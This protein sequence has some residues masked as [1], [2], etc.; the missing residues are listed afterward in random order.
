MVDSDLEWFS[1]VHVLGVS[2]LHQT[3]WFLLLLLLLCYLNPIFQ[4]VRWSDSNKFFQR[5]RINSFL[6]EEFTALRP[7]TRTLKTT[8]E[9]ICLKNGSI[10]CEKV[11]FFSLLSLINS[12]RGERINS[13]PLEEFTAL[14]P[15][16][17]TLKT[18]GENIGYKYCSFCNEHIHYCSCAAFIDR[19][20]T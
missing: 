5:E 11:W 1:S 12:F 4:T 17:R 19:D 2:L 9:N 7:L 16:T 13:F 15:L 10:F 6:L 3:N 18:T 14:R 8:G 20:G